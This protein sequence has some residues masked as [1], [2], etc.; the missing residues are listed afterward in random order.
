MPHFLLFAMSSTL[1]VQHPTDY[2]TVLDCPIS[3][4]VCKHIWAGIAVHFY[5]DPPYDAAKAAAFCNLGNV[6][7]EEDGALGAEARLT[8]DANDEDVPVPRAAEDFLRTEAAPTEIGCVAIEVLLRKFLGIG[9]NTPDYI[10]MV[11]GPL[12]DALHAR[13]PIANPKTS[14]YDPALDE[15]VAAME[16]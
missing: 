15:T 13:N 12:Q 16:M 8:V 11:P 4:D 3:H 7:A 9:W 1:P 14:G 6:I 2:V 5:H 10:V